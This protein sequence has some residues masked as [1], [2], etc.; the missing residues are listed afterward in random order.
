MWRNKLGISIQ[1]VAYIFASRLLQYFENLSSHRSE[2]IKP[3]RHL[4]SDL[5][6]FYYSFESPFN[7]S[8]SIFMT[9]SPLFHSYLILFI[10]ENK[11]VTLDPDISP[12][13]ASSNN[14]LCGVLLERVN[15]LLSSYSVKPYAWM[16]VRACRS[17]NS[18]T[19]SLYAVRRASPCDSDVR[20]NAR[21]RVR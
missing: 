5:T 9:P 14:A 11:C 13:F 7:S 8:L 2:P 17:A 16:T 19:R 18:S 6:D 10:M 1:V 20:G 15:A 4:L 3:K 21:A 12:A